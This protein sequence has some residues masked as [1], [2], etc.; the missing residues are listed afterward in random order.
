MPFMEDTEIIR[1]FTERSDT[2]V[3]ELQL[4]YKNYCGKIAMNIL[5]SHEESEECV[6]D[7]M[8]RIW[9]L[10]PPHE[11]KS[12]RAFLGKVTRNLALNRLKKLTA[13]KRGSGEITVVYE[14]LSELIS[15]KAD[16]EQQY[17]RSEII[18]EINTFLGSLPEQNRNIFVLRYWYCESV[19][20]IAETLGTNENNV[21]VTLS[22]VREKLKT[23]LRKRGYEI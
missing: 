10:I 20:S 15:G 18:R 7:A 17:E 13:E 14:E 16:I 2:A 22:R 3:G 21:S 23:H 6:N 8:M 19:K 1:K 12:L 5:G 4:K 9:E 11:P